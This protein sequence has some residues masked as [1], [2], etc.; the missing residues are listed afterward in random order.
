MRVRQRPGDLDPA[1]ACGWAATSPAPGLSTIPEVT[2]ENVAR[3]VSEWILGE[4]IAWVSREGEMRIFP[5]ARLRG[6]EAQPH[7]LRNG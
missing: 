3:P 7:R 4:Y 6:A 5:N 2:G 1:E